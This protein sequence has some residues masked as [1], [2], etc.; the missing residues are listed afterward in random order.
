VSDYNKGFLFPEDIAFICSK[1]SNVLLDT[2]KILGSWANKAHLIKINNY[3]YNNSLPFLTP[4]LNNKIISVTGEDRVF[5]AGK[6]DDDQKKFIERWKN[7]K[8][9]SYLDDVVKFSHKVFALEKC[10]D[11]IKDSVDYLIWL[12]ADVITK[13]PIDYEYLKELLPA[14]DEVVSYL[15]RKDLHSECGFVVYNMKAD[16][17]DL[18]HQMKNEYVLGTFN[19]YKHGITDCHVLDFCLQG[20]KFKNLSP[21]YVYGQSDINVWPQTRLAERM[22]H[23]KGNRKYETHEKRQIK[24]MQQSGVVD[25]DNLSVKT[26]NCLDKIIWPIMLQ[27]T[28][29]ALYIVTRKTPITFAVNTSKTDRRFITI[30]ICII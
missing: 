8:P 20:K 11:A 5:I 30:V 21:H 22:A 3:E 1:H 26:K 25:S 4:E 13:K 27:Y 17:Y 9:K 14:D 18:L 28:P 10:A 12:D 6:F 15:N 29:H 2:K 23:R 16:G 24:N 19:D 7:H